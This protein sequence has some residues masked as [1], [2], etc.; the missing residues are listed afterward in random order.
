MSHLRRSMRLR[1]FSQPSR[2]G[3]IS[4]TPTA[5]VQS[6]RDHFCGCRTLCV[7]LFCKGCGFRSP[8]HEPRSYSAPAVIQS[9][10]LLHEFAHDE[11]DLIGGGV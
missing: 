6:A 5:L 1:N 3:L 2:A 4:V 11:G 7:F 9:P 8:A 10:P